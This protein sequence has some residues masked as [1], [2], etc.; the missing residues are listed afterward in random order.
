MTREIP[1]AWRCTGV[2]KDGTRCGQYRE[3]GFDTCWRHRP[4]YQIPDHQRCTGHISGGTDHQ[5]RAGERCG[6]WRLTGQT[7]CGKHGGKAPAALEAA[8]I[9]VAE[10]KLMADASRLVGTP[11]DN[12]LTELAKLA[13]R[14]RALMDLLEERVD[15]LLDAP[16]D[17]LDSGTTGGIRYKGGAGEQIRGEVQLYERS[18]DRLGTL[19]TS[20]ARLNID[21]RLVKIEERQVEAVVAA[22]EAGL[23]A[24]GIRDQEQRALAKNTA[25]RI[26]RA[27]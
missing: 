17:D 6:N 4:G 25:A 14:A 20:I 12:P 24:A 23:T 10:E 18:M 22:L 13:G 2:K 26:L 19:L 16:D 15:A 21:D 11:V 5:D 8:R 9:R 7:V 1:D 3:D 27:V